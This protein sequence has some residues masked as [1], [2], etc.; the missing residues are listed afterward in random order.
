LL[1]FGTGL[2]RLFGS[3]EKSLD[4]YTVNSF[5]WIKMGLL[6]AIFVLELLPMITFVRWRIAG[7]PN[8]PVDTSRAP[9][10]AIISRIQAVMLLL[11]ILMATGMARGLGL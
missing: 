5:F 3:Y 8:K 4:Y 2:W 1:L 6:V 11:M 7:A 10:F 9:L